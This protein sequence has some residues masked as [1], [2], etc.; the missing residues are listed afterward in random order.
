MTTTWALVIMFWSGASPFMGG[1][2]A[3][4]P[5]FTTKANCEA[6]ALSAQKAIN[7]QL[8]FWK[9]ICVEVK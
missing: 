5:C 9:A 1:S 8:T 2:G 4:V 3:T 6:A 7:S